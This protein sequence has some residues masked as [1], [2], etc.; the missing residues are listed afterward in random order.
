MSQIIDPLLSDAVASGDVRGV[1]AAAGTGQGAIYMGATGT[2]NAA[3]DRMEPGSVF[4]IASMTK[5]VTSACAL[6]LWSRDG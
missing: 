6:S 1:A 4:W 3:G 5:A 2:R